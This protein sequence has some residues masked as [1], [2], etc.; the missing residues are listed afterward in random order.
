MGKLNGL[1]AGTS[2]Q[3]HAVFHHEVPRTFG[4]LVAADKNASSAQPMPL[5]ALLNQNSIKTCDGYDLVVGIQPIYTKIRDAMRD[6]KTMR[7]TTSKDVSDVTAQLA[8]MSDYY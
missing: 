7:S 3:R 8:S 5:V 2:I 6:L 4:R 1:C